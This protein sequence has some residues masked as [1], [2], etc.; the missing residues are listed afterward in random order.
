MVEPS[1]EQ[2][3]WVQVID[4]PRSVTFE[5]KRKI[6]NV[7]PQHVSEVLTSA[8]QW[9]AWLGVKTLADLDRLDDKFL[10]YCLVSGQGKFIGVMF[11]HIPKIWFRRHFF[12]DLSLPPVDLKDRGEYI[13]LEYDRPFDH[14]RPEGRVGAATLTLALEPYG[15]D[16]LNHAIKMRITLRLAAPAII[17]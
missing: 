4:I 17:I 3:C 8:Q 14:S 13:T 11:A 12:A 10:D 16:F 15:Q 1:N 5:I 6:R 7:F 9:F 2:G